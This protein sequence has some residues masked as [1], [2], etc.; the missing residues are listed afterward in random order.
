MVLDVGVIIFS[1]FFAFLPFQF[2]AQVAR[3]RQRYQ[4]TKLES[5]FAITKTLI[6]RGLIIYFITSFFRRPA[7]IEPGPGG[8]V[9][10]KVPAFNIFENGTVMVS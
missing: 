9:P 1:F 5:F 3:E 2:A 8:V 7:T 6:I 4:P 10:T